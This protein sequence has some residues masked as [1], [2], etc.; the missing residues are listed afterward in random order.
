MDELIRLVFEV[1]YTRT[2]KW[3]KPVTEEG[4]V[5]VQQFREE[6]AESRGLKKAGW[7]TEAENGRR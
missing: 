2:G 1:Y 7:K 6:L 5:A 3:V 4:K